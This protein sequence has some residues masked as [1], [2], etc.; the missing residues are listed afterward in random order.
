MKKVLVSLL[1]CMFT[2][3]LLAFG[4]VGKT[5]S[6]KRSFSKSSQQS[7]INFSGIK[8]TEKPTTTQQ[9]PSKSYKDKNFY[10]KTVTKNKKSSSSF[11][12]NIGLLA[13]GMMLGSLLANM[14][15]FSG[16]GMLANILGMV[17][18]LV[19][20]VIVLGF[21]FLALR[22]LWRKIMGNY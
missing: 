10:A 2:I 12:R 21:I 22:F 9:L 4:A 14:F 19:F 7:T 18:N 6:F 15:G 16:L 1:I 3:N 11:L 20:L 13:G 17:F 8:K 5:R